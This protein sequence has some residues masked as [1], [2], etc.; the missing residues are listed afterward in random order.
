MLDHK[1]LF[2]V[3]EGEPIILLNGLIGN[4]S[5]WGRVAYE[6]TSSHRVLIPRM[7]FYQIPV[8]SSRLNDLVTYLEEFVEAQ[9]LDKVTLIGNSLGGHI[10]LLYAWRQPSMVRKLVLASSSGN[11]ESFEKYSLLDGIDADLTIGAAHNTIYNSR[12]IFADGNATEAFQ[13]VNGQSNVVNSDRWTLTSQHYIECSVL[14]HIY[15]PTLLIW[16]L[17]DALTPPEVALA[18]HEHLPQSKI[19]FLDQCGHVP[20]VDQPKLFNQHVREFLER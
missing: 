6:F 11:F 13:R 18:F 1:P 19:I 17:K 16:G 12:E 4:L 2:D 3:G 7:P 8:S 10:A 15:A 20:M 9:A 5:N 14:H